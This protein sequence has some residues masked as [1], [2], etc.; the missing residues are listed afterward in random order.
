MVLLLANI[1]SLYFVV[2]TFHIKLNKN[3]NLYKTFAKQS[4]FS[5]V[6]YLIS[7]TYNPIY[8][9]DV[10]FVANMAKWG[11]TTDFSDVI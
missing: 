4:N 1:E 6:F 5:Q 11:P 9:Y 8:V 10:F 2:E 3:N 7:Q